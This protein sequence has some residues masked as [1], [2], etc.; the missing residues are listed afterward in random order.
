M[1]RVPVVISDEWVEPTG[2]DWQGCSIRVAERAIADIPRLLEEREGEALAMGNLAREQW[3]RWFSDEVAFHRVVDWCLQI[4]DR[5]RWPEA[6]AR[7]PAYL[8]LLRPF[9]LKWAL[10]SAMRKALG[11]F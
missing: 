4:R 3:Q 5:R 2:P 7:W 9:H 10:R 1:G 6:I 8:Q 11:S